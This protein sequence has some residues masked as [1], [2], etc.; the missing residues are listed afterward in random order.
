[1][2]VNKRLPD[3]PPFSS[4]AS[5]SASS[6][7]RRKRQVALNC[8]K[9]KTTDGVMKVQYMTNR[10]TVKS[11]HAKKKKVDLRKK[12]NGAVDE[13]TACEE[14]FL[15][16][17]VGGHRASGV[18][19]PEYALHYNTDKEFAKSIDAAVGIA[20]GG[21]AKAWDTVGIEDGEVLAVEAKGGYHF[22]P[23]ANYAALVDN[24]VSLKKAKIAIDRCHDP[25]GIKR[26][27]ILMEKDLPAKTIEALTFKVNVKHTK[28]YKF[29]HHPLPPTTDL[30]ADQGIRMDD[31]LRKRFKTELPVPL[32][33][34]RP[35]YALS[36]FKA[37]CDSKRDEMRRGTDATDVESDDHLEDEEEEAL[38]ADEEHPASE[39]E[40]SGGDNE[41]DDDVAGTK[42]SVGSVL[43]TP[44][45]AKLRRL[46]AK[47]L[48]A[49][50]SANPCSAAQRSAP[51]SV[52]S[53]R[54]SGVTATSTGSGDKKSPL[55]A[56]NVDS[57]SELGEVKRLC[58][59]VPISGVLVADLKKEKYNLRRCV[60]RSD[61]EVKAR[62]DYMKKIE[63]AELM[64]HSKYTAAADHKSRRRMLEVKGFNPPPFDWPE[65]YGYEIVEREAESPEVWACASLVF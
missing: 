10:C 41:D 2:K 26:D 8:S 63:T 60:F 56:K 40:E 48:V 16:Y 52:A 32:R 61:K 1:M 28:Y 21:L 23:E 50:E 17:N 37:V 34:T 45:R 31:K 6:S 38:E 24:E 65:R 49:H 30:S 62:A 12:K 51:P 64:T 59:L 13:V 57:V 58:D 33:G 14:C 29:A 44:P 27:G 3:V 53:S 9:C 19:F 22:C 5:A 43:K 42:E 25:F 35:P 47:S 54:R 4:G 15:G 11:V 7:G 36:Y 20:K 46:S 18:T 39:H 55:G